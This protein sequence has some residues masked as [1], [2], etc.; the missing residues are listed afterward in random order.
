MECKRKKEV[1]RTSRHITTTS[2]RDEHKDESDQQQE[3]NSEEEIGLI[4]NAKHV[5]TASRNRSS[6]RQTWDDGNDMGARIM[7]NMHKKT[8]HNTNGQIKII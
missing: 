6:K 3:R 8:K 4:R 1:T 2:K 7:S 5:T